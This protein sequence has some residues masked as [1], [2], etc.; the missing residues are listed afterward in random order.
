MAVAFIAVGDKWMAE[1]K[2]LEKT[3]PA[4]ANGDYIRA[5][6]FYCSAAGP[7]RRRPASSALTRKPRSISRAT[8]FWDPPM[9]VVHIPF[10]GKETSAICVFP[11]TPRA[12][13][14]W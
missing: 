3:D 9:E 4:K 6:R 7:S 8:K 13:C 5:W 10:E 11:R 1:A 2:S 12:L 14:Q